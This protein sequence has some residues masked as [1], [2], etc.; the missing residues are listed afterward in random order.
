MHSRVTPH[1]EGPARNVPCLQRLNLK[2]GINKNVTENCANLCYIVFLCYGTP[3][4]TKDMMNR[5]LKY[6]CTN[7]VIRQLNA[8][9]REGA[10]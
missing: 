2:N 4:K 9:V 7:V 1:S 3:T 5:L 8:V 10:V 6:R